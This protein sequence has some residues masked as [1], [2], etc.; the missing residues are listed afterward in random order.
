[1]LIYVLSYEN[2]NLS[3]HDPFHTL[4][5][6]VES[7]LSYRNNPRRRG[8]GGVLFSNRLMWMHFNTVAFSLELLRMGS[9]VFGIW[10]I[11][12]FK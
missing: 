8:G 2:F 10:G 7:F 12:K 11:T 3:C 6:S 5:F 4:S 9:H 1:M